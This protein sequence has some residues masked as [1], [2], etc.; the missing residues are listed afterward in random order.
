MVCDGERKRGIRDALMASLYK[1]V[2]V[3]SGKI[4]ILLLLLLFE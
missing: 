3:A 1:Q 4:I 2:G